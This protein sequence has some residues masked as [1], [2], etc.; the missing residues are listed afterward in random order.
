[1]VF[2]AV[3]TSGVLMG[4]SLYFHYIKMSFLKKKKKLPKWYLCQIKPGVNTKEEIVFCKI[5]SPQE[6]ILRK[7]H[8][9]SKCLSSCSVSFEC[10]MPPFAKSVRKHP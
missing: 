5:Y 1:M 2:S 7:F 6:K 10:S 8:L 9:F 3:Q 4:P